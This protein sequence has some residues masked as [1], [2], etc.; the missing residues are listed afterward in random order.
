MV[1]TWFFQDLLHAEEK[2]LKF[3][4]KVFYKNCTFTADTSTTDDNCW[5][6]A[7]NVIVYCTMTIKLSIYIYTVAQNLQSMQL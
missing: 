6:R 3:C 1:V 5:S 2:K 7:P 4:K